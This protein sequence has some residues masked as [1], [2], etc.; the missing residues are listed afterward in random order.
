MNLTAKE[1]NVL[2]DGVVGFT[3]ISAE[4]VKGITDTPVYSLGLVQD[5]STIA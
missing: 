5:I 1:G 4:K 3:I 2:A